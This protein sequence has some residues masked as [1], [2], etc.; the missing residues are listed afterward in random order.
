[1]LMFPKFD[2]SPLLAMNFLESFMNYVIDTNIVFEDV[3]MK[4]FA[5]SM[6]GF[7]ARKWCSRFNLK[8]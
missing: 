5:W 1:M 7:L 6:Q 3:L 8:K 4:A 2:G